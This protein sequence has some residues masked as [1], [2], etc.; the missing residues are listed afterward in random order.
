MAQMYALQSGYDHQNFITVAGIWKCLVK[1][2]AIHFLQK[3][4]LTEDLH[5]TK[6]CTCHPNLANHFDNKKQLVAC[7]ARLAPSTAT[8][9]SSPAGDCNT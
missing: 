5:C 6:M 3:H 2:C 1:G 7:F 9:V 8:K 4:I